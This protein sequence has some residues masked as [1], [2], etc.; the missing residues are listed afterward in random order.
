MARIPRLRPIPGIKTA[1]F[2]TQTPGVIGTRIR[3]TN[4]DGSSHVEEIVEWQPNQRVRLEMKEY[5]PPLSR[6]AKTFEEIWN[7]ER[8]EGQTKVSRSFRLH[9]KSRLAR[10]LL[11]MISFL[12][13]RAIARHLREMRASGE[14]GRSTVVE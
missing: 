3:V 1:V 4:L 11:W 8:E 14:G 9:A 10:C 5:S 12:L 6:L 2:D 7:F 13:K